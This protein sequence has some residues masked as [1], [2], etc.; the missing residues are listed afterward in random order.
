[1]RG[2]VCI[3]ACWN[4]GGVSFGVERR[5]CA[6]SKTD[7]ELHRVFTDTWPTI[8]QAVYKNYRIL[9]IGRGVLLLFELL[10]FVLSVF[11]TTHNASDITQN[12]WSCYITKHLRDLKDFVFMSL[13]RAHVLCIFFIH[14]LMYVSCESN[15]AVVN[16]IICAVVITI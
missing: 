10:H 2:S 16:M 4:K 8:P 11:L 12:T 7:L 14:W 15:D 13:S 6:G 9:N 5:A 3:L 1:M